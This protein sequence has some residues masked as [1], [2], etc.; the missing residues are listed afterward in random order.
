MNG[1]VTQCGGDLP[2]LD[3]AVAVGSLASSTFTLHPA[4]SPAEQRGTSR[5]FPPSCLEIPLGVLLLSSGQIWTGFIGQNRLS[6]TP[7]LH[8]GG[9]QA[10]GQKGKICEPHILSPQ[11]RNLFLPWESQH[12]QTLF[13]TAWDYIAFT[14]WNYIPTKNPPAVL[15][16]LGEN[17]FQSFFP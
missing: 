6:Q 2:A 8:C 13:A 11:Q 10:E 17:G 16:A 3:R 14:Q 12:R 5:T 1:E 7:F 15:Q 9:R 4:L